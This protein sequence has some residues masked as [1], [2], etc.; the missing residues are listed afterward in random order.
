MR[1]APRLAGFTLLELLV[2]TSISL[3]LAGLLLAIVNHTL[4]LWQRQRGSVDTAAQ[5]RLV[6]DY[7]ERDLQGALHRDDGGSW[8]AVDIHDTPAALGSHAWLVQPGM[9]P[10]GAESLRLLADSV[11]TARFGLSG[12]CLRFIASPSEAADAWA[13]PAVVSYQ[14]ARRPV[15]GEVS[16]D[17]RAEVRY[18]LYRT[19]VTPQVTFAN[20]YDLRAT[21]YTTSSGRPAAD[22][23]AAAVTAPAKVEALA[24][25]VVDFG[26]WL[27]VRK[28][29]GS[30]RRTFPQAAATLTHTAP[31]DEGF[32]TVADVMVRILTEAGATELAAME[33]GR[34]ARPTE[35]A[36]DAAWWWAVVERHSQVFT[37][38]IQIM[39]GG[40]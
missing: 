21:A 11:A 2:A 25:N 27:H 17:N 34:L 31:R 4:G 28:A 1:P 36:T 22:R 23:S 26:V 38:R 3:I 37:R 40:L 10:G 5:A 15:T 9:K 35:H 29:D 14:I 16:A 19:A 8:L 30:L 39:G 32:A 6:L 18:R 20:G 24:D 33:Q 13:L 7:L 12:C